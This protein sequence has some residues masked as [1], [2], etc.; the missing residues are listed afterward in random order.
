MTKERAGKKERKRDKKV[1]DDKVT[2]SGKQK[3]RT[4]LPSDT[5]DE[6]SDGGAAV[7]VNSVRLLSL[8]SSNT[9]IRTLTRC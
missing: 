1:S 2:K 9:L 5:S 3:K 6:S 4:E 8:A 7:L